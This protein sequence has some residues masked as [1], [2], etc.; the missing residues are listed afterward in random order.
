MAIKTVYLAIELL[1]TFPLIAGALNAKMS[2]AF[3]TGLMNNYSVIIHSLGLNKT[4]VARICFIL[5]ETNY[6]LV[7]E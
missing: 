1:N 4:R 2:V 6:I 7:C 5:N 3:D